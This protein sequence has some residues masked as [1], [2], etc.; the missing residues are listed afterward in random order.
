MTWQCKRRQRGAETLSMAVLF[1]P[2]FLPV[3]TKFSILPIELAAA[4]PIQQQQ[5]SDASR[6]PSTHSYVPEDV[7]ED[8]PTRRS[9][10]P[11][12]L[13]VRSSKHLSSSPMCNSFQEAHEAEEQ[14]R[15]PTG[16]F[17]LFEK[18][19]EHV[20]GLQQ[21]PDAVSHIDEA[22]LSSVSNDARELHVMLP[23]ELPGFFQPDEGSIPVIETVQSPLTATPG[24]NTAESFS[25]TSP[26]G[27]YRQLQRFDPSQMGPAAQYAQYLTTFL[28]GQQQQQQ[29]QQLQHLQQLQQ[30]LS[31]GG[32]GGSNP[33]AL[34]K[35]Q[36]RAQAAAYANSIT[37][38]PLLQGL[39]RTAFTTVAETLQ[40]VSLADV[41]QSAVPLP[42]PP[43]R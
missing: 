32:Q 13:R 21:D 38:H 14:Q 4:I 17:E 42:P 43:V 40:S 37:S 36:R 34:K 28:P 27:I 19:D 26:P 20:T 39:L 3:F 7:A 33:A 35:L 24:V 1:L 15:V 9:P 6:T 8:I 2:L 41:V 31:G 22:E 16:G 23:N 12:R 25:T 18:S 5:Q 29:L 10:V 11:G 30:L